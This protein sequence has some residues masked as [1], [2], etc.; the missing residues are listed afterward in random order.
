MLQSSLGPK[1]S[2]QQPYPSHQGNTPAHPTSI[3]KETEPGEG[4][5]KEEGKQ[6]L[7]PV[8]VLF[9]DIFH[10]LLIVMTSWATRRHAE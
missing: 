6:L 1:S 2:H 5:A 10:V 3:A 4:A 8:G 7:H 9:R